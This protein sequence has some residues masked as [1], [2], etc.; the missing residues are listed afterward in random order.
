MTLPQPR[1]HLPPW[2][3]EAGS[4]LVT[5]NGVLGPDAWVELSVA[6][7]D[8]LGVREGDLVRVESAR[9]HIDVPARVCDIREG[10]VF[11]PFHYGYW[12]EDR[13][14]PDGR[15]RAANELTRVSWDPVSK[16]PRFKVGAVRV[17]R[18]AAGSGPAPAPTTTASRPARGIDVPATVG[19]LEVTVDARVDAAAPQRMG[20]E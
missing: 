13:A 12:D 10:V 2:V 5:M 1:A 6:D 4:P 17:S 15:P 18:L 11:A 20:G 3:R 19:G 16:Q 9:G 8:R 14:G 7:A